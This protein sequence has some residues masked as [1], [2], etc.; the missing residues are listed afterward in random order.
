VKSSCAERSGSM[1]EGDG[2]QAEG[3]RRVDPTPCTVDPQEEDGGGR[4]GG[5]RGGA[6]GQCQRGCSTRGTHRCAREQG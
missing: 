3:T 6:V 1:E 5:W 4:V 2:G